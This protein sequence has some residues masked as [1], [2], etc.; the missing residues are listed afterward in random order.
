MS[1]T[2]EKNQPITACG[3]V[4]YAIGDGELRGKWTVNNPAYAGKTGTEIATG[5]KPGVL[6]GVYDVDIF[7]PEGKNIYQGK[8]RVTKV[9]ATYQLEWRSA[10]GNYSG[11]GL[12]AEDNMLAANYWNT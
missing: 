2:S 9:G 3:I 6:E 7:N 11:L 10:Q 5:G 12:P 4:V 1:D 8:L